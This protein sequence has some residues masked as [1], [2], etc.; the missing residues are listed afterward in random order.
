VIWIFIAHCALLVVLFM[1][2]DARQTERHNLFAHWTATSLMPQLGDMARSLENLPA[3]VV[4]QLEL[5]P[6]RARERLSEGR[7]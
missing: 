2:L 4:L 6:E 1:W 7:P 3:D 5:A